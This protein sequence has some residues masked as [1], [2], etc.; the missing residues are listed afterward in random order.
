G[1]QPANS[2]KGEHFF[3]D[4][5]LRKNKLVNRASE[6]VYRELMNNAEKVTKM[7]ADG[8]HNF[9][10]HCE[11]DEGESRRL[12]SFFNQSRP[13]IADWSSRLGQA[14]VFAKSRGKTPLG[15]EE[16]YGLAIKGQ[17]PWQRL[18][19]QYVQQSLAYDTTFTRPNRR[20]ISRKLYLPGTEKSNLTILVAIDTSGSIRQNEAELF[21][22]ETFS[23]LSQF[24]RV[25]IIV[26]QCDAAIQDIQKYTNWDTP[27]SKFSFKGRGGTNF[28]PIFEYIEKERISLD[29]LIYFTDGHAPFPKKSPIL[30]PV[31]WVLTDRKMDPPFGRKIYYSPK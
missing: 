4:K 18:L 10:Q 16:E 3:P 6:E 30:K 9:D 26:I 28:K 8:L 15:L 22:S 20:F 5:S 29:T 13:R 21:I 27:P 7:V 14:S 1:K 24:P 11:P 23:I 2:L 25:E 19:A 12:R 17:F 31:F